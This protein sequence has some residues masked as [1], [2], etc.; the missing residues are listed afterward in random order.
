MLKPEV[1]A[2]LEDVRISTK[3]ISAREIVEFERAI[4]KEQSEQLQKL[5][6]LLS[7]AVSDNDTDKCERLT[8]TIAKIV[9]GK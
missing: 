3:K 8:T 4:S 2:T 1:K 7:K 6:V 5:G 9:K